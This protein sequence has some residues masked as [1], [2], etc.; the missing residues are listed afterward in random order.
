M[1]ANCPSSRMQI[2]LPCAPCWGW[3]S[4][5][6]CAM[7]SSFDCARAG[8][9]GVAI[10]SS[11]AQVKIRRDRGALRISSI[12]GQLGLIRAARKPNR[13]AKA[14]FCGQGC[15]QYPLLG[16]AS[17]RFRGAGV[18]KPARDIPEKSPLALA[19]NGDVFAAAVAEAFF[20]AVARNRAG[21]FV[22]IDAAIGGGLCKFP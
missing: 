9:P 19:G 1:V 17:R 3:P 21:D 6:I 20:A 8:A 5:F 10:P 22:G 15:I 12:S 7:A 18:A 4:W 16:A 2:G 11:T 14:A 13:A